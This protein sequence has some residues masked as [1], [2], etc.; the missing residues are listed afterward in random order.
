VQAPL[1]QGYEYFGQHFGL[2]LLGTL[3]DIGL[4]L[5]VYLTIALLKGN[6]YWI[7]ELNRK[8]LLVLAIIGFYAAVQIEQQALL[9]DQWSYT[10]S[11]PV[12][13]YLKAG[14]TPVLQMTILLPVSIYITK[15]INGYKK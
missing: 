12:I 5:F 15:K 9:S 8:D 14:L 4:T 11:M 7:R 10:S 2:C 13:P 6:A 3:G 1:Y